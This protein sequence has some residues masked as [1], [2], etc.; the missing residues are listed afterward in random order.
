MERKLRQRQL[1]LSLSADREKGGSR[2]IVLFQLLRTLSGVGA[3]KSRSSFESCRFECKL[4]S[5]RM[6]KTVSEIVLPGEV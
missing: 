3:K 1:F 4:D 2:H 6:G 5:E